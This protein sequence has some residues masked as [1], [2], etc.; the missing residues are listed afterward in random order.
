MPLTGAQRNVVETLEWLTEDSVLQRGSGRSLAQA[1][2]YI[3]YAMRHPQT[4]V[5]IRD[6]SN[7]IHGSSD[8]N[9]FLYQGIQRLVALHNLQ[10]FFWDGLNLRSDLSFYYMGPVVNDWWPSD[11][12]LGDLPEVVQE[13]HLFWQSHPLDAH[14]GTQLEEVVYAP[15]L[16][17]H[18]EQG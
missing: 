17:E 11:E 5:F 9:R 16:W 12:A 15:T 7:M 8:V 2:A 10:N 3:R 4:R 13:G 18:L 1:V 14:V 6:H